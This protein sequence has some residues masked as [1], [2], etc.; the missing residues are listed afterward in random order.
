MHLSAYT[1]CLA[2]STEKLGAVTIVT[3]ICE[4]VGAEGPSGLLD[5]STKLPA[6]QSGLGKH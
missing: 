1:W 5:F 6:A 4:P 2:Q 3:V